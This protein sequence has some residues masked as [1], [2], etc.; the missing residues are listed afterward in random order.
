[1][2][3]RY[4][5]VKHERLVLNEAKM[6]Q[7]TIILAVKLFSDIDIL[8]WCNILNIVMQFSLKTLTLILLQCHF[9]FG[10][11]HTKDRTKSWN[12]PPRGSKK[13]RHDEEITEMFTPSYFTEEVWLHLSLRS[14]GCGVHFEG[15]PEE[16]ST[17][18]LCGPSTANDGGG[19][20]RVY[21]GDGSER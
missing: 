15:A 8:F 19:R 4:S 7:E 6:T 14:C 18:V 2:S 11:I 3:S 20:T 21:K 16:T 10:R 12:V 1:M 5:R 13:S 17:A 9:S